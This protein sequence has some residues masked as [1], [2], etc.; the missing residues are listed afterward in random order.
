MES[1]AASVLVHCRYL[2]APEGVL[3]MTIVDGIPSYSRSS[4]S[5]DTSD[6][7]V[8]FS[9]PVMSIPFLVAPICVLVPCWTAIVGEVLTD[10][11]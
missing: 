11:I 6:D 10:Y 7:Q 5:S 8:P 1:V 4:D 2:D 3:K 9:A